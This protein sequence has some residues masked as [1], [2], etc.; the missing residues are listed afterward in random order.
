MAYTD[1]VHVPEICGSMTTVDLVGFGQMQI[2]I[3]FSTL[4]L[5]RVGFGSTKLVLI[6]SFITLIPTFGRRTASLCKCLHAL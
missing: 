6:E 2:I 5:T 1:L 3:P 4:I